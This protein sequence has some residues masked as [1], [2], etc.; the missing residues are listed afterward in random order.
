MPADAGGVN[1]R[2]G[3]ENGQE[4]RFGAAQKHFAIERLVSRFDVGTRDELAEPR[5]EGLLRHHQI[6]R[7]VL[8]GRHQEGRRGPLVLVE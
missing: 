1:P 4:P 3:I 5:R 6:R 8:L 2:A 7:N